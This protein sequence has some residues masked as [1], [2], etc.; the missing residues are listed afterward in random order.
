MWTAI[1]GILSK[2][3]AVVNKLLPSWE[4]KGGQ[5][6]AEAKAAKETVD[7]LEEQLDIASKPDATRDELLAGMRKRKRG[8]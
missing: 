7:V 3:L 6:S 5:A 8:D 4:W 2:G 1:L